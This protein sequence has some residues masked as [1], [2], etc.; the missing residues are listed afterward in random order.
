MLKKFAAKGKVKVFYIF[1]ENSRRALFVRDYSISK[2]ASPKFETIV[3]G[4][5]KADLSF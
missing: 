1:Y 2:P 4:F 5:K 3:P